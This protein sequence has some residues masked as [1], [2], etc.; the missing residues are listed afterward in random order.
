M[1]DL[2]WNIQDFIQT[3]PTQEK[4]SDV[5]IESK[6]EFWCDDT[7]S[8]P[9]FAEDEYY[10]SDFSNMIAMLSTIDRDFYHRE[11]ID[12]IYPYSEIIDDKVVLRDDI[13]DHKSYSIPDLLPH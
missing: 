10:G 3:M 7:S 11:G 1:K 2:N 8:V 12:Y 6:L 4:D 5:W 13:C 9:K